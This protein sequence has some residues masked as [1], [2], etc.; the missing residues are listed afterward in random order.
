MIIVQLFLTFFA[1]GLFTF[2]GGYAMIPMITEQVT[3]KGWLG[4]DELINFIGIAESTPGPFAV[5]IATFVGEVQ[6]GVLGSFAAT[7]GVALPSFIIIIT[8]AKY[9]G[10]FKDNFYVRGSIYGLRASVIGLIAA[11]T[12][13]I[14]KTSIFSGAIS[15]ATIDFKAVFILIAMFVLSRMKKLHPIYIVILSAIAGII[16]YGLL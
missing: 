9:F 15:S 7:L 13:S 4:I 8:I 6:G 11:A 10:N 3:G 12:F 16:L 2:G 5:N 1:I 14:F